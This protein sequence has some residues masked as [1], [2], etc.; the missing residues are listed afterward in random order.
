[1]AT[2]QCKMIYSFVVII[3]HL[4]FICIKFMQVQLIFR[5]M[6]KHHLQNGK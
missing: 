2:W 1:M 6:F 3:P 4:H 5:Q